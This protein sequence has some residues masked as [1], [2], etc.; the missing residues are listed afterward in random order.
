MIGPDEGGPGLRQLETAG[1][2]RGFGETVGPVG[3][4]G[5]DN[6]RAKEKYADIQILLLR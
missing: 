6:Q 5:V 4:A 3:P 1:D 2:G